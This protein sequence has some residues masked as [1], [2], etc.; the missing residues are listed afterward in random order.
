MFR[1]R[2]PGQ[3]SGQR[4]YEDF[5]AAELYCPRCRAAMPVRKRLLLVLPDG[6]KYDYA[7]TRCGE[8]VGSQV[9]RDPNRGRL[10]IP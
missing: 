5:E 2:V 10:L 3:G 4:Q 9:D 7:C 8:S 6:D 1:P